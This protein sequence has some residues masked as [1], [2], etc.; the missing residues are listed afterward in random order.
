[1][2]NESLSR[3][4]ALERIRILL[5]LAEART[6]ENSK[7]SRKLAKRYTRIVAEISSHYKVSI[8]KD[9]KY[10]VCKRCGNFLVPGINCTVRL[11]SAH[12]YIA[13]ACECGS[14]RHFLYKKRAKRGA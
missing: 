9:L 2:K 10:R 13:Y 7:D 8:P 5:A 1:M 12:G 4:I 6:A 3:K 14:E 11:A